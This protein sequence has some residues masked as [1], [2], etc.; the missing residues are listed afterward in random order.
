MA[1]LDDELPGY[2]FAVHKGYSTEHH[3]SRVAELG[4]SAQHRMSYR[5]VAAH[6]VRDTLKL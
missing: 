3:M 1:R 2:D 5:N 6:A 4:P